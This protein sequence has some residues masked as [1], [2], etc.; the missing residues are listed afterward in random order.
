[1]DK[2]R[3][4]ARAR[5]F[6]KTPTPAEARLWQALRR[7]TMAGLKWRRQHVMPPYILDF[8]CPAAKQVV[9]LDGESHTGR[10]DYDHARDAWLAERGILVCRYPNAAILNNLDQVLEDVKRIAESRIAAE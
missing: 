10:A 3:R 6:R 2:K 7:K 1:M 8:Y 4:V 9:E 5:D